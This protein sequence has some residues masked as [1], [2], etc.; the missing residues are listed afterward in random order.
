MLKLRR[1]LRDLEA[2]NTKY[3][4]LSVGM[5]EVEQASQS[6]KPSYDLKL[7]ARYMQWDQ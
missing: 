4:D 5:A 3:I 7:E 2:G 1:S 6:V